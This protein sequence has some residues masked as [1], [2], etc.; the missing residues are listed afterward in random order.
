MT[1]LR[2]RAPLGLSLCLSLSASTAIAEQENVGRDQNQPA[3]IEGLEKIERCAQELDYRCVEFE[4]Q[5]LLSQ[6]LSLAHRVRILR[7]QALA[8][9]AYRDEARLTR[10]LKALLALDPSYQLPSTDP[11]SVRERLELIRPSSPRG[12]VQLG[13]GLSW[14]VGDDQRY[15]DQLYELRLSGAFPLNEESSL[16]LALNRGSAEGV[17]PL[18]SQL[19]LWSLGLLFERRMPSQWGVTPALH[20]LLGVDRASAEGITDPPP[21]WGGRFTVGLGLL[22]PSIAGLSLVLQLQQRWLLLRAEEGYKSSSL[23]GLT[24][25]IRWL[26]GERQ[27]TQ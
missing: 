10:S 14:L 3:Q 20:L 5:L 16:G 4:S 26:A 11:N 19:E 17:G 21:R 22:S 1:E 24:L 6:R 18:L 9:F 8:A 2:L 13:G 7:F 15:W 12:W 25:S 27:G 23:P